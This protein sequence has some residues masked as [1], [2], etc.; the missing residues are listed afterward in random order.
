MPFPLPTMSFEPSADTAI[1]V[2][3]KQVTNADL[4]GSSPKTTTIPAW[5]VK[6]LKSLRGW[7]ASTAKSG[8]P[9]PAGVVKL[10][11]TVP[12]PARTGWQTFAA[13]P[14]AR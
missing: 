3:G 2:N 4:T 10:K 1:W 7:W 6:A 11:A 14:R 13:S 9:Q 5:F 12:L 8:N